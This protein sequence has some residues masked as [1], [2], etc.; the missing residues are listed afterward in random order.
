M[1]KLG[2]IIYFIHHRNS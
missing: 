2:T 1:S